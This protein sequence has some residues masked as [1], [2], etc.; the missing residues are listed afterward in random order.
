MCVCVYQLTF[1]IRFIEFHSFSLRYT[2][3]VSK[4]FEKRVTRAEQQSDS[5]YF[6]W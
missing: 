1:A 4:F 2:A 6:L 3:R 5:H